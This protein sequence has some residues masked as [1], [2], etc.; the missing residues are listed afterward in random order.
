MAEGI[1]VLDVIGMLGL[2]VVG[3]L[4]WVAWELIVARKALA[5]LLAGA[6]FVTTWTVAASVGAS[7]V[8]PVLLVE[9]AVLALLLRV[10]WR[11]D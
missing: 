2:F 1:G 7:S 8:W 4:M 6:T 9:A 11:T 3:F 5:L 10:G